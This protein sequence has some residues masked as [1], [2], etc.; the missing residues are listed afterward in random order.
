MSGREEQKSEGFI[1]FISPKS[2]GKAQG[3][4]GAYKSQISRDQVISVLWPAFSARN[5]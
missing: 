2:D 4:C 5:F 3:L 1:R